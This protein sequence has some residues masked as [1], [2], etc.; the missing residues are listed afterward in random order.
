[1]LSPEKNASHPLLKMYDRN[2]QDKKMRKKNKGKIE[3]KQKAP[4][5]TLVFDR[6]KLN[7]SVMIA[8]K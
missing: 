2:R 8:T 3:I 5:K 4:N 1:M 6:Q 7:I